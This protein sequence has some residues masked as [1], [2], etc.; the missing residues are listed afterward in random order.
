MF[1]LVLTSD[2]AFSRLPEGTKPWVT[3]TISTAA[4]FHLV[5]KQS[6]AKMPS[7][8]EQAGKPPKISEKAFQVRPFLMSNSPSNIDT[9][10]GCKWPAFGLSSRGGRW[11]YIRSIPQISSYHGR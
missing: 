2:F 9:N 3:N 4:G 1:C 7:S 11:A 10:V 6:V 5:F 8:S